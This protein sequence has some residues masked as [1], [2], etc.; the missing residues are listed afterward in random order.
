MSRL[1][2]DELTQSVDGINLE[3]WNKYRRRH[4]VYAVVYVLLNILWAIWAKNFENPIIA[5]L[6]QIL[7]ILVSYLVICIVLT[8]IYFR[9][10]LKSIGLTI[11]FMGISFSVSLFVLVLM[12]SVFG[13]SSKFLPVLALLGSLIITVSSF[14][15]P[16][17]HQ[18]AYVKATR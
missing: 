7:D 17:K 4:Q 12:V 18:A 10:I 6:N 11:I 8:V 2:D 5:M 16:Q 9:L 3:I 13:I 15:I 14:F 1:L